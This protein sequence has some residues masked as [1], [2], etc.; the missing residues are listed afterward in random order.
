M[1]AVN[2]L[3]VESGKRK[4]T[5]GLKVVGRVYVRAVKVEV[6]RAPD[7]LDWDTFVTS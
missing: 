4:S 2:A 5:G 6:H 3:D 7:V 1:E